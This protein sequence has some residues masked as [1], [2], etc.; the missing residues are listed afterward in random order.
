[1][2]STVIYNGQEKLWYSMDSNNCP[3]VNMS[4]DMA[5]NLLNY[6]KSM[7]DQGYLICAWNGLNFDMRWIGHN[8]N[9]MHLAAAIA[10]KMYDPMFQFFN[11]RGFPISLAS[12]AK[13]MG[14]KQLKLMKG[15]D[16]PK[17][18]RAGNYKKVMD[19]VRGDSQ[20]TNL[21]I[22]E[23]IRRQEIAWITQ[24]GEIGIEPIPRLKSVEEIL[25]EPEPDQTWMRDPISRKRF[26]KWFPREK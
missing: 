1:M 26:Y 17:E 6:L 24:R 25:Q 11:R 20:I 5:G 7:Q 8:A 21:I 19:Y 15:A 3:L 12:V 10:R 23:I 16:A 14:I 9:D 2:A 13:A 18:W 4:R 22:N